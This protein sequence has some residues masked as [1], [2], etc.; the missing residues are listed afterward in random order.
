LN[1][2]TKCTHCGIDF[3]CDPRNAK[4]SDLGC[5][6]GCSE[7]HKKRSSENRVKKYYSTE[8][9]K[10]KKKAINDL[11]YRKRSKSKLSERKDNAVSTEFIVSESLP[12]IPFSESLDF[13]TPLLSAAESFWSYLH[14]LI[15]CLGRDYR[16]LSGAKAHVLRI[17]RQHSMGFSSRGRYMAHQNNDERNKGDPE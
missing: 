14:W 17:F 15:R 9:G 16:S 10:A 11:A 3:L 12:D 7:E 2:K 5:P 8:S 4:R 6:F 1:F 13:P